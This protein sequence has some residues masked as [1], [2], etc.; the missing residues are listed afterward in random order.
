MLRTFTALHCI[1]HCSASYRIA[2]VEVHSHRTVATVANDKQWAHR[3][4]IHTVSKLNVC[5]ISECMKCVGYCAFVL[6]TIVGVLYIQ[7]APEL[8]SESVC[9]Q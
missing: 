4:C 3:S 9:H 1:V 8:A 5:G 7:C 6:C 2:A